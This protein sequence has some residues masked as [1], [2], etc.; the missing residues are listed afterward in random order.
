MVEIVEGLCAAAEFKPGERVKTLRGAA[1]G[2]ILSV[3]P[4]GRVS[5]RP[6]GSQTELVALPDSLLRE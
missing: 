5:W 6:D 3:R 2:V 4:D 1:R